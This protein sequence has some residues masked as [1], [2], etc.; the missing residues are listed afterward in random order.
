MITQKHPHPIASTRM[1]NEGKKIQDISA[2]VASHL[3]KLEAI[4][5]SSQAENDVSSERLS[6]DVNFTTT[7]LGHD[8]YKKGEP[9]RQLKYA[10]YLATWG[11]LFFFWAYPRWCFAQQQA[12]KQWKKDILDKLDLL[13]VEPVASTDSDSA[14]PTSKNEPI[15]LLPASPA[16]SEPV[17]LIN[18]EHSQ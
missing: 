14:R 18:K 11:G 10:I 12:R 3:S 5:P 1:A 2:Q 8:I 4:Q 9:Y 6:P 7:I 17:V 13:T 15:A 16:I